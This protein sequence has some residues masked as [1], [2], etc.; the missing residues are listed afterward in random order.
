VLTDIAYKAGILIDNK[1][2]CLGSIF[3]LAILEDRHI[4]RYRGGMGTR[5]P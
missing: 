3:I 2:I 5:K 4:V 1:K